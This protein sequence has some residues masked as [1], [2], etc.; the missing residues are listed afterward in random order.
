MI[1]EKPGTQP[2]ITIYDIAREAGVSYA[3]VSRALNGHADVGP[4]TR[5]RILEVSKR[6]NYR[7][8]A[9][10]RGLTK[11]KSWLLGVIYQGDF[12][13][14]FFGALLSRAKATIEPDGYELLFFHD[15]AGV[16][17]DELVTRARYRQI[18][19]LIVAGVTQQSSA[20]QELGSLDIPM[21]SINF[22]ISPRASAVVSHH[23]RGSLDALELLWQHGHRR[24][25][26]VAGDLDN[27]SGRY[28]YVAYRRFLETHGVNTRPE[29]VAQS[30]FDGNVEELSYARVLEAMNHRSPPTA[31]L[32]S[33]DMMAIGAMRALAEL[34]LSVPGDV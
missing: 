29:W 34:G 25:G 4:A 9:I 23:Y 16:T 15:A 21:V 11:K 12:D 7:P 14:P 1:V 32:C 5:E 30:S 28:R 24:I 27:T 31:W 6:L 10:A 19:G 13:N 26:F 18:D 33:E 3:T 2:N 17:H 8:R 22:R 20:V